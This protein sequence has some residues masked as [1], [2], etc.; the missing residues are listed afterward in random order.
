M[1]KVV[2]LSWHYYNSKRRAGFHHLATSLSKKK[3]N[4]V[5]IASVVSI[6]TFL[7][8]EKI[9]YEKHF[10][11][12]SFQNLKFN[13]VTSIIN[14]SLLRPPLSRSS[15][16]FELI[17]SI[18]FR[19]N[20]KSLREISNA[21]TIVFESTIAI[22]FF[23]KV[24]S[25]NPNARIIY[26]ASDDMEVFSASK[27]ILEFEKSLLAKFDV[28]SVTTRSHFDKLY[29]I[30]PN[31]LKL[32]YHGVDKDL[33]N[34]ANLN[35]F[36]NKINIVFVGTRDLD[37]NFIELASR[38]FSNYQFHVVGPFNPCVKRNNVTYHGYM[39]FKDTLPY[40][41]YASIALQTVTSNNGLI[42]FFTDSNKIL[43]YSFCKL[44]IIAPS[45]I[46]AQ[47]R[48]NFFYYEY[49]DIKSIINCIED[50]LE[51]DRSNLNLEVNSWDELAL[52]LIQT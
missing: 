30:S 40:I 22:Y 18:F 28:V 32:H 49:N 26:R 21:D 35:P 39:S 19:L 44:P 14:F 50:A 33:F 3:Y 34:A 10:L 43:Q 12:N 4:V 20:R 46:N 23:Y 1:H 51:F 42:S 24:K 8:R 7:R 38:Q 52:E 11:R 47:H 45:V 41:K 37:E 31:N 13:N 17:S 48:T 29:K 15:P 5:F 25:I 2:F 9:L 27:K 16:I 6:F 36:K